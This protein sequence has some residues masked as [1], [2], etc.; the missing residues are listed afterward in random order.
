MAVI[1]EAGSHWYHL[2]MTDYAGSA[3]KPLRDEETGESVYPVSR[4]SVNGL[5]LESGQVEEL[6]S[7]ESGV[8]IDLR[9]G[10]EESRLKLG[11]IGTGLT[12]AD[13]VIPMPVYPFGKIEELD[14]FTAGQMWRLPYQRGFYNRKWGYRV[15]G[16]GSA[17][18]LGACDEP[19]YLKITQLE[20]AGVLR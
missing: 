17:L 15:A 2:V 18:Q 11:W 20:P 7:Y 13:L 8:V 12:E 6:C 4:K 1:V 9:P 14:E 10:V 3:R 16:P 5:I 19:W